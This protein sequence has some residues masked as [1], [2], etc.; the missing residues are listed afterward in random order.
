MAGAIGSP[1]PGA[2]PP[3]DVNG[4]GNCLAAIASQLGLATEE[5]TAPELDV[6]DARYPLLTTI[7]CRKPS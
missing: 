4:H 5:L 1:R 2:G 6:H 3:S 7:V